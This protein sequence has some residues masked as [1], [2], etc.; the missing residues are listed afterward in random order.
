MVDCRTLEAQLPKYWVPVL[1]SLYEF[2]LS[3]AQGPTIWVPGLLGV[4]RKYPTLRGSWLPQTKNTLI[5]IHWGY[6]GIMEDEMET[7]GII[8]TT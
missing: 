7:I 2:I 3:I 6:I 8:G 1:K 5:F 4:Y